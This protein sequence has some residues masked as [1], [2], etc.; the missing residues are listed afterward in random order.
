MENEPNLGID[1]H[2][3]AEGSTP[4]PSSPISIEKI[5]RGA[6]VL[7]LFRD[8]H[9]Y[10]Q[11]MSR[12]FEIADGLM[13]LR[14][15]YGIWSDEIV[16]EFG[17]LLSSSTT[18]EEL[19]G[20]SELVW[21][22][23]LGTMPLDAHTTGT[24]WALL[25]TGRN[26]RWETIGLI[27]SGVGVLS[28]SLSDWDPIFTVMKDMVKDRHTLVRRMRKVVDL[29][30]GFCKECESINELFACLLVRRLHQH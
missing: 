14:P 1:V 22:N 21:R 25:S 10:Q 13:V 24:K 8:L 16:K 7:T 17:T 26:L 30:I 12:W 18:A 27:F 29:C 3:G 20:F 23:T 5:K 4:E 19:Y 9:F 6:E 2:E 15:V 28:G 11:L